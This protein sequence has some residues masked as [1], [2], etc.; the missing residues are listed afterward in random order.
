[1]TTTDIAVVSR[2]AHPGAI[3]L[4]LPSNGAFKA[5][6][7]FG[8]TIEGGVGMQSTGSVVTSPNGLGSRTVGKGNYRRDAV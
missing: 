4:R 2:E 6:R 5:Q 3:A 1:V 8:R 7:A